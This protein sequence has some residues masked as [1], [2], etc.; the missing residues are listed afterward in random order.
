MR[1]LDTKTTEGGRL[2]MEYGGRVGVEGRYGC[3]PNLYIAVIEFLL[4]Q[5]ATHLAGWAYDE[6]LYCSHRLPSY[7]FFSMNNTA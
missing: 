3:K 7:A 2:C 4:I 6:A 1:L 5:I